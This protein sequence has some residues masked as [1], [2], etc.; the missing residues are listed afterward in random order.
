MDADFYNKLLEKNEIEKNINHLIYNV[1]INDNLKIKF[2]PMLICFL[3]SISSTVIIKIY[4][5]TL[6]RFLNLL[7]DAF[8][9]SVGITSFLIAAF[10]IFFTMIKGKNVYVFLLMY[11]EGNR[12][13]KLKTT[14]YNF[15]KPIIYFTFLIIYNFVFKLLYQ[16]TDLIN[17]NSYAY[18]CIKY[19]IIYSFFHLLWASIIELFFLIYNIYS[20]VML[21][22]LDDVAKKQLE[23]SGKTY[24]EY[25]SFM[26]AK[27]KKELDEKSRLRV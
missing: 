21:I 10:T 9:F 27:A 26:E 19:I 23:A 24:D 11:E 1:F 14:I 25:I 3:L 8:S 12:Q 16:L 22:I 4:P 18:L 20:F 5:N 17:F 2:I 7:S 15:I 6:D 13:S